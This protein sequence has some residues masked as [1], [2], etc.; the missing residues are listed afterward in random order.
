MQL[1]QDLIV[2]RILAALVPQPVH[3]DL[4]S[5]RGLAKFQAALHIIFQGF[6]SHIGFKGVKGHIYLMQG[7]SIQQPLHLGKQRAVGGE[8]HP[9]TV[10]S[11]NRQKFLQVRMAQ[12]LAHQVK[13]QIVRIGPQLGHQSGKFRHGHPPAGAFRAGAK[14]AF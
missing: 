5:G 12:R 6:A 10:A 2:Q 14:A 8:D 7:R 4:P 1:L 13:I 9:E 3:H 11:R